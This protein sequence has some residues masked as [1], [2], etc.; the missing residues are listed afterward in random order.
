[1]P[2]REDVQRFQNPSSEKNLL[3]QLKLTGLSERQ[4]YPEVFQAGRLA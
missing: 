4:L 3:A 1:M 2:K